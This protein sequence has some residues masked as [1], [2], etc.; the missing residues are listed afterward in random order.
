MRQFAFFVIIFLGLCLLPTE[1]RAES[2]RVTLRSSL[3]QL[4]QRGLDI[5][6]RGIGRVR[7]TFPRHTKGIA[8]TNHISDSLQHTPAP[9][10]LQGFA[11]LK[12]S[13]YTNAIPASATVYQTPR[14]RL[15]A[16]VTFHHQS[17]KRLTRYTILL[18][19]DRPPRLERTIASHFK[20]ATCGSVAAPART[21]W[22]TH[23]YDVSSSQA[24]PSLPTVTVGVYIDASYLSQYGADTNFIQARLNEAS[25]YY[26]QQLGLQLKIS[27]IVAAPEL[28]FSSSETATMLEEFAAYLKRTQSDTTVDVFHLMTAMDLAAAG[29]NTPVGVAYQGFENDPGVVCRPA[30]FAELFGIYPATVSITERHA[31]STT[32][33][34][35]LTIAHEIAHNLSARHSTSGIM[36]ARIG[37]PLPTAF[38]LES[39]LQIAKYLHEHGACIQSADDSSQYFPQTATT[40]PS[41]TGST[42]WASP[43]DTPELSLDVQFISDRSFHA[44]I[45]SSHAAPGCTFTIR[46][47][48]RKA[49]LGHGR[50]VG[51]VKTSEREVS[52]LTKNPLHLSKKHTT[53]KKNHANMKRMRFKLW[54]AA[55][56][57]CPS[58]IET[59]VSAPVRIRP[60]DLPI[61]FKPTPRHLI[62]WLKQQ[63]QPLRGE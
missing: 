34:L 30:L 51:Q 48:L 38:A 42:V 56:Q 59:E 45:S 28:S 29:N 25:M 52:F 43:R 10:L 22:S 20:S 15:R 37:F 3:S 60:T 61:G 41:A 11:L 54:L 49:T 57:Q 26:E 36:A 39:Q 7:F 44:R 35:A 2:N 17:R 14:R 32:G 27:F 33:T 8:L 21:R 12:N 40:L 63:L 9:L 31:R 50:I 4:H 6:I 23:T 18:D 16:E 58:G 62:R 24:E 19:S 1:G 5:R 53:R 55:E 46:A 13:S 47:S